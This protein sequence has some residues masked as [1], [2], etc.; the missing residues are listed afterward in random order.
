MGGIRAICTCWYRERTTTVLQSCVVARLWVQW[1]LAVGSTDTASVATALAHLRS[2]SWPGHRRWL[3][4]NAYGTAAPLAVIPRWQRFH[5]RPTRTCGHIRTTGDKLVITSNSPPR[6]S[7]VVLP[8]L[9]Y[10]QYTHVWPHRH[11]PHDM[12][13]WV[14]GWCTSIRDL[15]VL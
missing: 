8:G 12:S 13:L 11:I 5:A 15:G 7:G 3:Q 1:I 10:I 9:R 2:C 6:G 4:A 14:V